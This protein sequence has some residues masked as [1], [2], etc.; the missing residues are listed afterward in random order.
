MYACVVYALKVLNL[1]VHRLDFLFLISLDNAV[2]GYGG[3]WR[4]FKGKKIGNQN[5]TSFS[6]LSV[7]NFSR[8]LNAVSI[9]Y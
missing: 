5:I 2:C 1:F 8:F 6:L 4:T 9:C 7:F 3:Q